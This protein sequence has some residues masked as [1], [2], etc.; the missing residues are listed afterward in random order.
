MKQKEKAKIKPDISTL[1]KT[2]HFY[3]GLTRLFKNLAYS[4]LFVYLFE[5]KPIIK[6]SGGLLQG[7]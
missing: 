4:L 3:F 5:G 7:S 6:T 2:G 1:V